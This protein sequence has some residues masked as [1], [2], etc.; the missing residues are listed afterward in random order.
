MIAALILHSRVTLCA[1]AINR[2]AVNLRTGDVIIPVLIITLMAALTLSGSAL[3][4]SEA[5]ATQPPLVLTDEVQQYPLGQYLEILE[6]PGGEL[7][8]EDVASPRYDSQFVR[9]KVEVPSYGF[10]SSVYWVRIRLDNE[11]RRM[12]HWL[13]ELAF[14]GM[15]YADLYTPLPDG[16]GF[17]V[18]QTGNLRP[19]ETRDYINPNIVFDLN[20]PPHSQ[21][22]VY[23]RFQNGSSMTLPLILWRPIDFLDQT[24]RTQ[25]L[26][27][28]YFGILIGLLSYNVFLLISLRDT[29]HLY[30][31]SLLAAMIVLEAAYLGYLG[32]DVFPDLYYL[33]KYYLTYSFAL[34]FVSTVL[35]A[36]SFLE[37]KTAFLR[38]H[39]VNI[40]IVGIWGIIVLL[41]PFI[42]YLTTVVLMVSLAFPSLVLAL[43]AGLFAWRR[44]MRSARFYIIAWVGLLVTLVVV[45]LVRLGSIPSVPLTE[46]AYRLGFV[47]MGVSWSIALADRVNLLKAETEEGN[48][49]LRRSEF[50]LSQILEGLPVGV[51]MYGTDHKPIYLNHRVREILGNPKRGI[52]PNLSVGR[53]L[54]EAMDYF[55][56]RVTDTTQPYPLHDMP[57]YQA[58]EGVPASADNIAADLVDKYVPLEIWA[59][60]VRD[61]AGNVE[62]A[63]VAFQDITQRKKT[64]AELTAFREHLET[65]VEARTE[66][67]NLA[68][69]QLGFE[70]SERSFL[71]AMQNKLI[72]WLYEVSQIHQSLS[73]TSELPQ[74]FEQ[75]LNKIA[76][77]LDAGSAYVG[78]TYRGKEPVEVFYNAD[79]GGSLPPEQECPRL[80]S[81]DSPLSE[82]IE[83]G[84]VI[85]LPVTQAHQ[86]VERL[87]TC[88]QYQQ[89]QSV[90]F[91]PIKIGQSVAGLLGL[92]IPRSAESI[93]YEEIELLE[94]M[95]VDLANLTEYAHVLD[96]GHALIAAEERNRLARDLHDSVTQVLFSASLV[97]EVLPRIWQRDHEKALQSLERLRLLTH[98]A[99]AE[100]R[101][102]LLELRPTALVNTP[103]GEL[104]AQLT[105]AITTRSGLTF[106]MSIEQIPALP[107]EVHISFYRVAQEALNNVVKHAQA[108]LVTVSL[109]AMPENGRATGAATDKIVLVIE[110]DGVG[111]ASTE[112]HPGHLGVGIMRERAA[113]IGASL[114]LESRLGY[115]SCVT[116]VWCD[117]SGADHE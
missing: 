104:L 74:I 72:A 16:D 11:N 26:Q 85:V 106:R 80:L 13:L 100:M 103:V 3:A 71:Q 48:R 102:M 1:G 88:L 93:H 59:S 56:F 109:S 43:L 2:T 66:E 17:A 35:F 76:E 86:M 95:A 111:Y 90:I 78:I 65:L 31:V 77:L 6:D 94:R 44:H 9:S 15:N 45:L 21:Q 7:T 37:L 60:P 58:L 50:R 113:A 108:N 87:C 25:A 40:V 112:G 69:E 49:A 5:L 22:T 27:G 36:D 89:V 61:S 81:S 33:R 92:G 79:L 28:I 73:T 98:G 63:V 42:S 8:I 51:V 117:N 96:Q 62:S 67:L 32:T 70:I 53:T 12:D 30:L 75:L 55:S 46:N 101:T 57:V 47:W 64:E 20:I 14:A 10:T 91:V 105:E 107:E 29:N 52:E 68:N 19:P 115:G 18:K 82:L 4:Q 84:E 114:S 116:L 99:L 39:Q 24:A 97:A 23:L 34:V 38:L 83:Q 41:T 54:T 110:D